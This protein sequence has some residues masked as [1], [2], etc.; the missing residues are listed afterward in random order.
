MFMPKEYETMIQ[1]RA[2]DYG[3]PYKQM[4]S[5]LEY[6]EKRIQ[7]PHTF[8]YTPENTTKISVQVF[9]QI[10]AASWIC[11]PLDFVGGATL[12]QIAERM[13]ERY[14]GDFLK[15]PNLIPGITWCDYLLK[16]WD[17]DKGGIL[18][19]IEDSNK[20]IEGADGNHRRVVLAVGYLS[21]KLP[22]LQLIA[23]LSHLKEGFNIPALL[24]S[25]AEITK[26][27]ILRWTRGEIKD[28][29]ISSLEIDRM[30]ASLD[31]LQNHIFSMAINIERSDMY[32]QEALKHA[33]NL[34]SATQSIIKKIESDL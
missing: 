30:K 34:Q 17:Y 25:T 18:H 13:C 1:E 33:Y 21:G 22:R 10:P 31:D 29:C 4:I 19:L 14:N 5:F 8:Y 3:I 6:I 12:K 26:D 7:L 15:L 16:N 32:S 24:A 11:N 27:T 23:K 20:K 28:V 9:W 2:D